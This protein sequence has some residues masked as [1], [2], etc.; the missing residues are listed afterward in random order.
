MRV[1]KPWAVLALLLAVA[2]AMVTSAGM[3]AAASASQEPLNVFVMFDRPP[4]LAEKLLIA[5]AGGTVTETY[6]VVPAVSAQIPA[7]ALLMIVRTRGVITVEPQVQV[8]VEDFATELQNVWGVRRLG[9]TELHPAGRTGAGVRVAVLD[10]GIA[11]HSDL[12][13]DPSCSFGTSYGTV[14]DGHGHGTHV[15]GTIAAIRN[16]TGVVGMAP[17]ATLCI[18]KVLGD[19][20][21]GSTGNIVSALNWISTFNAANPANPIRITN[22]SYGASSTLGSTVQAAFDRLASDGVLNIASAGN[23]GTSGCSFP[24]RYASVVAVAATTSTDARASFSS[25]CAEVELAA[26]GVNILSTVPPAVSASGYAAWSGTSMASPHV[27]R[28][29][30]SRLGRRHDEDRCRGPFAPDRHRTRPRDGRP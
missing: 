22:N 10:T 25:V 3:P 15:A 20:G 26:P 24:A 8:Q 27:A 12:A 9:G 21:S 11:A 16:G 30:G 17:G 4:G 6:T 23:S 29:G 13:Y 19:D 28:R 18:F 14:N 2:G 5:K 1:S 7:S